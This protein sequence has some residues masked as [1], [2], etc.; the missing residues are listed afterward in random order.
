MSDNY[1]TANMRLHTVALSNP[2]VQLL[3][4]VCNT[5]SCSADFLHT[6]RAQLFSTMAAQKAVQQHFKR[7]H[8]SWQA[9][10]DQCPL[11]RSSHTG[12]TFAFSLR[13][14]LKTQLYQCLQPSCLSQGTAYSA[15]SNVRLVSRHSLSCFH[16]CLKAHFL[17]MLTV[18]LPFPVATPD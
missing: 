15:H 6:L 18:M 3:Y 14:C 17:H 13:A 2:C 1:Y 16:A 12:A 5:Q 10:P 11:R 8:H 9:H 4:Q 7:L